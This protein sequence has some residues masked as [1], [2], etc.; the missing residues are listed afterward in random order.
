MNES[1]CNNHQSGVKQDRCGM[2]DSLLASFQKAKWQE[3]RGAGLVISWSN[4]GKNSSLQDSS[5]SRGGAN[6][7]VR[8]INFFLMKLWSQKKLSFLVLT[9]I[10]SS[11]LIAWPHFLSV[12]TLAHGRLHFSQIV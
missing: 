11:T 2:S 4:Q 5:R 7:C 3:P 6:L 1:K 10:R 12:S 9:I 8:L